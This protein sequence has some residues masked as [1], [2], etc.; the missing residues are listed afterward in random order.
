MV[1]KPRPEEKKKWALPQ[2]PD[3]WDAPPPPSNGRNPYRPVGTPKG[4]SGSLTPPTTARDGSLWTVEGD[5]SWGTG[6]R[7]KKVLNSK[8]TEGM[9]RRVLGEGAR[10]DTPRYG[11]GFFL[12]NTSLMLTCCC[13]A[14]GHKEHNHR[15]S[16][17]LLT[18]KTL[19]MRKV[20]LPRHP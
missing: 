6:V 12:I 11:Y 14:P 13:V 16:K 8:Q 10:K 15:K 1:E 5:T 20:I 17:N 7:T 18:K 9:I 2:E 4:G 19:E 3:A